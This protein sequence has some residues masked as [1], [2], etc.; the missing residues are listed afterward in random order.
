MAE[1]PDAG[2]VYSDR[3]MLEM[4]G[5]HTASYFKPDWN[6]DLFLSNMYLCH[7]G[8]YRTEIAQKAGLRLD[9]R[10]AALGTVRSHRDIVL[11]A[12]HG[13]TRLWPGHLPLGVAKVTHCLEVIGRACPI[14][15]LDDCR[16]IHASPSN[17][18]RRRSLSPA[19]M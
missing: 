2:I 18:S 14:V 3:D 11:V 7:L 10:A 13:F 6:P 8:I 12:G 17:S 5:R 4:D 15:M 9:S 1:H 16:P 19:R